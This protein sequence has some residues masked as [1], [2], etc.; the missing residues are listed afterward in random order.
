MSKPREEELLALI[1]DPAD[2]MSVIGLDAEGTIVRCTAAATR[3]LGCGE[4]DVIGKHVS[5]LYSD[6]EIGRGRPQEDLRVAADRGL[7]VR[8]RWIRCSG[9]ALSWGRVVIRSR[10][11]EEGRV[12]G[13][14]VATSALSDQLDVVRALSAT[15]Q[16]LAALVEL[17]LEGIV[18]TDEDGLI[19]LFNR[20]A[21]RMFG[22]ER[23][24][25]L[26]EPLRMLIPQRYHDR[27]DRHLQEFRAGRSDADRMAGGRVVTALAKDGREFPIEASISKLAVESGVILS[28]ILRDVSERVAVERSLREREARAHQLA[29]ALPFPVH[30]VDRDLRHV[31]ANPA[32]AAWLGRSVDEM[33][34]LSLRAVARAVGSDTTFEALLPHLEAALRGEQ[35]RFVGRARDR[36]GFVRDVEILAVPS[37][38]ERGAV[39]GCYVLTVDRTEEHRGEA[40]RTV[41]TATSALLGSSLDADLSVESAVRVAVAGFADD[42]AAYVEEDDGIVHRFRAGDSGREADTAG[43]AANEV[44]DPVRQVLGDAQ[45]R[46]YVDIEDR[47]IFLVV[48]IACTERK[49]GALVFRW[50]P[51]FDVGRHEVE[52]AQEL[53]RRLAAAIDRIELARRSSEAIRARD[54]L[55]HKVTHDLGNPVASIVMVVD[56]LLRT[57]PDPDRRERSRVLLEGIKQQSEEMRLIIEELLDATALR[58]GRVG[59][60]PRPV[61]AGGVVRRAASL[62]QSVAEQRSVQVVVEAPAETR[63]VMADSNRLRHGLTALLTDQIGWCEAGGLVRI[64]ALPARGEVVFEIAGP[65]P[66]LPAEE[67]QKLLEQA[68]PIPERRGDGPSLS[69]PLLIGSEIIRAHGASIVVRGGPEEGTTYSFALPSAV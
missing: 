61:D 44:P 40:A 34:G 58:T 36:D 49:G 45:T 51:P 31:F 69:L 63:R 22:Y 35:R 1:L 23:A 5:R 17:A 57:A 2:D 50:A 30:F 11:G 9:G 16:R 37:R 4:A 10:R 54:W 42:C 60:S 41:L 26:G 8:D 46:S 27:H 68:A 15:D 13:F 65:G 7:S 18:S 12:R 39:D 24:E 19:V 21:E 64:R 25:V 67:I 59:V 66:G 48:P 20:G 3:A 14:T 33:P 32:A 52:L 29:D 28:A 62:L 6:E 56:R 55:L 43:V 47:S 53:G 38:D